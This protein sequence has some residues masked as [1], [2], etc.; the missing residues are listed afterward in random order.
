M[1]GA[2]LNGAV[3]NGAMLVNIDAT[4]G[5]F[6]TANLMGCNLTGAIFTNANLNHAVIRQCTLSNEQK[7]Y[8]VSSGA[9]ARENQLTDG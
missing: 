4:K 6:C 9:D 5:R 2:N 7:D 8:A 3:L 1:R